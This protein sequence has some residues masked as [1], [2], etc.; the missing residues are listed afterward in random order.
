MKKKMDKNNEKKNIQNVKLGIGGEKKREMCA[1]KFIN[2][3]GPFC[4]SITK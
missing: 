2:F 1:S 4:L 3:K